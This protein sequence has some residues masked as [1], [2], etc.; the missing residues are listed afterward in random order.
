MRAGRPHRAVAGRR[1]VRAVF[2]RPHRYGI[3]LLE[4]DTE[5][6]IVAFIGATKGAS[7]DDT[8]NYWKSALAA[9]VTG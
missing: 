2:G 8:V 1:P 4:W 5:L 6:P 7:A 3:S 9:T